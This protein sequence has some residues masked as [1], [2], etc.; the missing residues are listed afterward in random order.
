MWTGSDLGASVKI[1]PLVA[2]RHWNPNLIACVSQIFA[3]SFFFF[4]FQRFWWIIHSGNISYYVTLCIL[5]VL[6]SRATGSEASYAINLLQGCK[7]KH[8]IIRRC[9]MDPHLTL[10]VRSW[11]PFFQERKHEAELQKTSAVICVEGFWEGSQENTLLLFWLGLLLLGALASADWNLRR[12]RVSNLQAW[13]RILF[14]WNRIPWLKQVALGWITVSP[15]F[16]LF[17]FEFISFVVKC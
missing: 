15:F 17:L 10:S 2:W 14:C 7:P 6:I 16:F 5:R 9:G 13:R 8:A 4:F 12:Q 3:S 1:F 11:V